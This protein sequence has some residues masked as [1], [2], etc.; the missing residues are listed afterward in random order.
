MLTLFI[1]NSSITDDKLTTLFMLEHY[2]C[3]NKNL[4]YNTK[5]AETLTKIMQILHNTKKYTT[6]L[7]YVNNWIPDMWVSKRYS[8]LHEYI[9][10]NN[11]FGNKYVDTEKSLKLFFA[12]VDNNWNQ[13]DSIIN[14]LQ[15]NLYIYDVDSSITVLSLCKNNSEK[16]N[17]VLSYMKEHVSNKMDNYHKNISDLLCI[18]Y[19]ILFDVKCLQVLLDNETHRENIVQHLDKYGNKIIEKV[20][21]SCHTQKNYDDFINLLNILTEYN[22]QPSL[23]EFKLSKK[24]YPPIENLKL[25]CEAIDD[26]YHD[27]FTEV[28]AIN[29]LDVNS[30]VKFINCENNLFTL[31]DVFPIT[32]QINLLHSNNG[33]ITS[34]FHSSWCEKMLN[35]Y[36][37]KMFLQSYTILKDYNILEDYIKTND[38][39]VIIYIVNYLMHHNI[40]INH[41]S[42]LNFDN[43]TKIIYDIIIE[44]NIDQHTKDK[45]GNTILHTIF[46]DKILLLND[47]IIESL[48]IHNDMNLY[49][50][51]PMDYLQTA[52][53][54]SSKYN[55]VDL[56]TIINIYN[57]VTKKC[58]FLM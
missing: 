8:S 45:K 10:F 21:D 35:Y 47:K 46:N 16:L 23:E 34:H 20:L 24:W 12:I 30:Y 6:L 53:I 49:G 19:S 42:D 41:I 15:Y 18:D 32:E 31:M 50:M 17:K 48:E 28:F 5:I 33:I 39:N 7:K 56:S 14:T 11:V 44:N 54:N 36:C 26:Y 55:D 2:I 27:N 1:L 13:L 3:N 25:Y 37:P 51:T 29:K 22:C 9:K 57:K 40:L 58:D 4:S 38:K 52:I 43:N